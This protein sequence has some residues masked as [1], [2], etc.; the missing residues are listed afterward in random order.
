M[1]IFFK[2]RCIVKC[3]PRKYA[4]RRCRPGIAHASVLVN[5]ASYKIVWPKWSVL[6]LLEHENMRIQFGPDALLG[7]RLLRAIVYMYSPEFFQFITI[8]NYNIYIYIY[9]K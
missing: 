5:P 2:L 3:I 4:A 8:Y 6:L 7:S 1:F 9:R